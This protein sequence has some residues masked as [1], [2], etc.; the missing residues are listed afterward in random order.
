[1]LEHIPN[2]RAVIAEMYRILKP[3][4]KALVSVPIHPHMSPVTFED[5][6]MDR[7]KYKEVHG[8]EDHV[9]S[10]GLDY[11]VRFEEVGFRTETLMVK[12]LPELNRK[13]LCLSEYH[14]VWLFVK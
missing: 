13:R 14:V 10:C 12:D 4:G 9:R 3:G 5:P 7:K 2:D 1:M 8:N 6:H 11:Y